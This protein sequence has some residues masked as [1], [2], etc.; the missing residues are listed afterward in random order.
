[1]A[2]CNFACALATDP[3]YAD[4]T[5]ESACSWP[6]LVD[7]DNRADVA[8]LYCSDALLIAPEYC[9]LAATATDCAAGFGVP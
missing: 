8:L 7:A 3:E 4:S 9:A 2:D 6:D 5:D 1:M